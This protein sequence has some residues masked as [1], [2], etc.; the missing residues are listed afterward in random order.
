MIGL[1][2]RRLIQDVWEGSSNKADGEHC[3]AAQDKTVVVLNALEKYL[4]RPQSGVG[5]VAEL[6][7]DRVVVRAVVAM[8]PQRNLQDNRLFTAGMTAVVAARELDRAHG[9]ASSAL[10]HGW[11]RNFGSG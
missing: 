8:T 2:S 4:K 10:R 9:S 5:G 7:P 11:G 1:V 3:H 6:P